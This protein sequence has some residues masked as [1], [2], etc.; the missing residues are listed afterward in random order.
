[1]NIGEITIED[2]TPPVADNPFMPVVAKLVEA[3]PGKSASFDVD[4]A[5]LGVVGK[6]FR[7][8]ANA[9]DRTAKR[10]S[11][12]DNEN[13]TTRVTFVLIPRQYRPNAG[14]PKKDAEPAPKTAKK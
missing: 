11:A 2:Y 1:M 8:A 3:G 6:R 7:E 9:H 13:G 4:T 12:V 10:R 5:D 14:A